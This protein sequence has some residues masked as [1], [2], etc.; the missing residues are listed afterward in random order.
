MTVILTLD[1]GEHRYLDRRY[2][3]DAVAGTINEARGK[4][5]LIPFDNNSTPSRT[6]WIDPDHV[7]TV[8]NDG[9]PY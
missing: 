5:K 8:G 6:I 7:V 1:T 4:G 9:N 3:T 2:G